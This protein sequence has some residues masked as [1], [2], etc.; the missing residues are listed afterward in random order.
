MLVLE[1]CVRTGD[2]SANGSRRD[3]SENQA[4]PHAITTFP[5]VHVTCLPAP[6]VMTLAVG[7]LQAQLTLTAKSVSKRA[8]QELCCHIA[9][10]ES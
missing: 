5:A 8:T 1:L 3:A 7:V 2:D 4:I 10:Q 6:E 9:V